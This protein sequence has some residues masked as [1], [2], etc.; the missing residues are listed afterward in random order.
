MEYGA[1]LLRNRIDPPEDVAFRLPNSPRPSDLPG[2]PKSHVSNTQEWTFATEDEAVHC[3]RRL[4]LKMGQ[5][6]PQLMCLLDPVA[7]ANFVSQPEELR[8]ELRSDLPGRATTVACMLAQLPPSPELGAA[9]AELKA[10]PNGRRLVE[11]VELQQRGR[12]GAQ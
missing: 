9:M 1:F 12:A 2:V 8:G 10:M 4:A 11:W 5:I 7:L 3:G 6:V